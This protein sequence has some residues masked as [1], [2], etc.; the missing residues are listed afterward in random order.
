MQAEDADGISIA[1]DAQALNGGSIRNAAGAD[2][3]RPRQPRRRQ[4]GGP[5][6]GRQRRPQRG[7]RRWIT[8]RPH[9]GMAYGSGEEIQAQVKFSVPLEV[10]GNP[11]LALAVGDTTR[12]ASLESRQGCGLPLRSAGGGP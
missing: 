1:A 2:A 12:L 5:Q 3:V 4:C 7:E 6:G 9:D 11:T 10:A 8:S